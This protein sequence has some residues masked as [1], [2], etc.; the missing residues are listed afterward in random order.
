MAF[1]L[2]L[3]LGLEKLKKIQNSKDGGL[4]PYSL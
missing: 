2:I 3:K 4:S 1:E